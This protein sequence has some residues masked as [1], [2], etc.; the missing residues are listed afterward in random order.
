MLTFAFSPIKLDSLLQF[1]GLCVIDEVRGE[2][3]EEE[4][5]E[6]C[7]L[8]GPIVADHCFQCTMLHLHI[9]SRTQ[10]IRLQSLQSISKK[11]NQNHFRSILSPKSQITLP[12]GFRNLYRASKKNTTHITFRQ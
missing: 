3:G 6:D 7:P 9:L 12:Q 5:R 1:A 2:V 10:G 11:S 4:H 8:W